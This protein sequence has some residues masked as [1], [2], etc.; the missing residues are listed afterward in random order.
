MQLAYADALKD[1]QAEIKS[2]CNS[3]GADFISACTDRPVE[4]VLFGELLKTGIMS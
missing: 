4:K 3:R 2:Y 1:M